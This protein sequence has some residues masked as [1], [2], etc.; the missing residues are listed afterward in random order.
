MIDLRL[1]LPGLARA[2]KHTRFAFPRGFVSPN[3]TFRAD[4]EQELVAKWGNWHCGENKERFSDSWTGEEPAVI[5]PFIAGQSVRLM[6][7]GDQYWQI[8]L[9]GRDWLKSLHDASADFM[10]VD[11]ELLHDTQHLKAAFGLQ[12]IGRLHADAQLLAASQA[13]EQAF[14]ASETLRRPLPDLQALQAA[15]PELKSIVT[16]PPEFAADQRTGG[17]T[18]V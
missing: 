18:A 7:V 5:E 11:P 16:H 15:R 9:E 4:A 6:M 14:E 10:T 12:V 17:I 8:K 1:K 2:L 3:T 13:L